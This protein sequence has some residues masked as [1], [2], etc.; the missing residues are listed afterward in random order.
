M[1]MPDTDP[2]PRLAPRILLRRLTPA[3]LEDF[4]AYR[5]DPE[6]ARYQSWSRMAADEALAFL[7]GQGA[8]QFGRPGW[9]QIG[10]AERSTGCLVGDIG[11]CFQHDDSEPAEIGFTLATP[12]QGK[13]L[14]SEAVREALALLFEN[15]EVAEVLAITDTRNLASI[16]LLERVGF[17]RRQTVPAVFLGEPCTEHVYLI[18]RP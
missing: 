15:T 14:A 6:V 12:W 16:H 4:Q 18:R 17:R 8:A 5:S 2:F 10:I 3:D 7:A 9:F 13:G 11:I 1:R